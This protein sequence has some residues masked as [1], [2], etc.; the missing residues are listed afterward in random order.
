MCWNHALDL[1]IAAA[2]SEIKEMVKRCKFSSTFS[3]WKIFIHFETYTLPA[4]NQLHLMDLHIMEL[5]IMSITTISCLRITRNT[6]TTFL[7]S[8]WKSRH[9][10]FY[11]S[12]NQ[13]SFVMYFCQCDRHQ[14]LSLAFCKL[15]VAIQLH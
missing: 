8:K 9:F 2:V 12:Y 7:D 15:H 1:L 11:H 4:F 10:I 14:K 6:F 5:K 3:S 13:N